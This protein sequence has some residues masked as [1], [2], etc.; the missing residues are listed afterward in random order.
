[1]AKWVGGWVG[2]WVDN[3]FGE[4]LKSRLFHSRACIRERLNEL[5]NHVW[6]EVGDLLPAS[7]TGS[8]H[9]LP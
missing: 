3:T 2:G 1:M 9:Y 6:E 4:D 7:S 8:E 5:E